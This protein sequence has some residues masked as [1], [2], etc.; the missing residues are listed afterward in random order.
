[1]RT[2]NHVIDSKAVKTVIASLP[3]HWVVREL[4]ERDYGIDMMVEIFVSGPT[5]SQGNE[6]YA[7]SGAVFHVQIK[8]TEEPLR[9]VAGGTINYCM[10]KKGLVY[11]E[12][13]ATLFFLLRVSVADPG[14]IYFLWIQRYIRSYMDIQDPDWREDGRD[15]KT[16]CIPSENKLSSGIGKL[17]EIAFRP[18]Y[19][20]EQGEFRSL[21]LDIETRINSIR[22]REQPASN[23]LKSW[24]S[25][26]AR[27]AQRLGALF[28]RNSL[29][30]GVQDVVDLI[31]YID[32]ID[33]AGN[34]NKDRLPGIILSFSPSKHKAILKR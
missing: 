27:R 22:A 16:V 4:T 24:L 2:K 31:E 12:R 11:A 18:K 21:F 23:E 6:A 13:F 25:G 32:N 30:V 3:D 10:K 26:L 8:G 19:L 14:E 15:S 20:E 5:D 1:M 29:G 34:R 7:A 9:A 28:G 17:E 33:A